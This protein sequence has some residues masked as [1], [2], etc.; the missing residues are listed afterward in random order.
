MEKPLT[1][2]GI[3]IIILASL[4]GLALTIFGVNNSIDAQKTKSWPTT[5]GIIITSEVIQSSRFVPHIVYT[6]SVNTVEL[7]S[8]KIGLTNYAQYKKKADA[9]KQADK[10]PVNT[11][12]TVY[13]NPSNIGEAILS[14]GIN[15]S[16]I[17]MIFL[18]LI[19]CLAPL[20]GLVYS[21]KKIKKR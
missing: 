2:S 21:L 3:L 16:H 19:I 1:K 7:T 6:Y 5:D 18:G 4:A 17:F 8:E 15:G 12:V 20:I 9:A 11:K 14:P 13:Y 10:Y